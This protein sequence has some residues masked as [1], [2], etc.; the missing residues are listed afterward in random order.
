[1]ADRFMQF[2]RLGLRPLLISGRFFPFSRDAPK[3]T[4]SGICSAFES[5]LDLKSSE[6]QEFHQ[7]V[8][9]AFREPFQI[10]WIAEDRWRFSEVSEQA[11]LQSA[12]GRVTTQIIGR[13]PATRRE[14]GFRIQ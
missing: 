7:I 2:P 14:E 9:P 4:Q 13:R 6:L 3:T 11:S 8:R 10:R 1:M 12:F 5:E